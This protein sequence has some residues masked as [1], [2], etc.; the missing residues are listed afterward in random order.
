MSRN[1]R[2]QNPRRA[3]GPGPPLLPVPQSGRLETKLCRKSRLAQTKMPACF[4]DV[5]SWHFHSGNSDRDIHA[6][7][8][9]HGFLEAGDLSGCQ[10]SLSEP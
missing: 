2:E 3:I 7:D 4:A 6:F 9:I 10:R 5:D 1:Y 8:P